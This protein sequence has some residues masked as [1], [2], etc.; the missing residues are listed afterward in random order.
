M[1]TIFIRK[2]KMSLL[3]NGRIYS[4]CE[5]DTSTTTGGYNSTDGT[6]DSIHCTC[7]NCQ[8]TSTQRPESREMVDEYD[9]E[10]QEKLHEE[11]MELGRI[12]RRIKSKAVVPILPHKVMN[13]SMQRRMLNGRR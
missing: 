2:E 3:I 5:Y 12:A 6:A 13:K 1:D 4:R 9:Y 10:A 8:S 7:C 11:I